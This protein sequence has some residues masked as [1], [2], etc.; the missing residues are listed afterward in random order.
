MRS[1]SSCSPEE[2]LDSLRISARLPDLDIAAKIA[3]IPEGVIELPETSISSIWGL[4]AMKLMTEERSDST[5]SL[6]WMDINQIA[7]EGG[8][9]DDGES[10]KGG[11]EERSI[12]LRDQR[13][14]RTYPQFVM[15]S[16]FSI[17]GVRDEN[18]S[19]KL[20]VPSMAQR[21][22]LRE[23]RCASVPVFDQS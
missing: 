3:R 21:L 7:K 22:R 14:K 5:M 10:Q 17:P 1:F 11:S 4:E 13:G 16:I 20:F 18:S 19:G 9:H 15:W 8:N 6:I 12:R 23:T 2:T